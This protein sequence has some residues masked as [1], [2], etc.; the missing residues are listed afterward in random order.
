MTEGFY[1]K[2]NEE[3]L[4][5]PNIVEGNG[6]VLVAQDKDQYDYP[7]DGWYWFDSEEEALQ[8]VVSEQIIEE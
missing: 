1:K 4:Y 3:L 5:A 6:F 2:D 8:E 7:V